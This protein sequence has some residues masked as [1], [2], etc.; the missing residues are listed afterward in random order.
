M[1]E[2][3]QGIRID[4][5][6]ILPTRLV[7]TKDVDKADRLLSEKE[8]CVCFDN[9]NCAE[10]A[11]G[12]HAVLDFGQELCGSLRMICVGAKPD[13]Y[14]HITFGESVGEAL[15]SL[16]QNNAGNDHAPRDFTVPVS[17]MSDLTFGQ[18][19]FRFARV[20]N[21]SK[22][23]IFVQSILAVATEQHFDKVGTLRT[24]DDA[25]N[26]ILDTA[27]RTLRLCFQNGYIWDGIKRDRLVWCGDLHQEIV[28]SLYLFGNTPN[29]KNS[30]SF[31][32]AHTPADKWIN[33]IATYSAWWVINFCD[34]CALSGDTA[35]RDENMDYAE[36]ILGRLNAAVAADGA[37]G[38]SFKFLD[39]PTH[40]T[41]DEDVGASAVLLWAAQKL[42]QFKENADAR[43]V[44]RKLS[45]ILE[46]DCAQ[47]QT[48]AFQ[49]LTGRN[50]PEDVAFL[51]KD[52]AHGF[53]TFMAY[54]ILS[55][56]AA[57]GGS[58]MLSLIREYFGGMLSRGATT[59]WEDFD[60]DWLDGS[61]RI[62]EIPREG[63]KDIHGDYG[64]FCYLGFRHS[65]CHGWSSGVLAF[66]IETLFGIHIS[67]SDKTVCVRPHSTCPDFEVK[68]PLDDGWLEVKR[69]D[70]KIRTAIPDGYKV[71]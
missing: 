69:K 12:A 40:K 43:E 5:R 68:L 9:G 39:W 6:L 66:V 2:F 7:L 49:I 58:A 1:T 44:V 3:M 53:S 29:V 18:S 71:V 17:M 10:F 51:E 14:V 48:R 26:E 55:A 23:P 65:L 50:K 21:Q 33:N 42:L 38:F 52:G 16:G 20:E 22:T 47:K 25:L 28:S 70:G 54:Y 37:L 31:L 56:D 13:S 62:D 4:K 19:G 67:R 8:P 36:A 30:L 61:G 32:R 34:Y 24:S 57:M 46:K 15:S 64:K 27:L 45:P 60:L 35:Y 63:E 41:P 59:F 11:P